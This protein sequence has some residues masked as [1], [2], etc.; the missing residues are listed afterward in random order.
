[1]MRGETAADNRPVAIVTGGSG[2]IGLACVE[3]F[4]CAGYRVAIGDFDDAGVAAA[5]RHGGG[6]CRFFHAD[7]GSEQD[8]RD[9]VEGTI[10]IFGQLNVLVNNAAIGVPNTPVHE[11]T[12]EEF[13]RLIGANLRGYF[14]CCKYAYPHLKASRGCIVNMSSMAGVHGEKHHAAYAATKG[15]INALTFSVAIDYGREGIRCNAI[16]PSSVLTPKVDAV[17]AAQPNAEDIVELRKNI[18]LLGYTS[19]PQEI[20]SV[21]VFLASPAASFITG[22][23]IPV[24]GGTECGYGVKY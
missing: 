10:D 3:A 20:A 22:A 9:L 14:L 11:T 4:I 23:L 1:M 17:I 2:G 7:M 15:G 21:A 24:S 13:D 18:N 8:I 5:Q 16:C 6:I 12:A 19:A